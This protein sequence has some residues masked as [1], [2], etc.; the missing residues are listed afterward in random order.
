MFKAIGHHKAGGAEVLEALELP[1][2][3]LGER[4][5]W[6]EVRATSL[7]P[8]DPKIRQNF[9]PAE[10]GPRVLGY[11]AAG[12]VVRTGSG[13][14][15]FAPGD[16][17]FYA[18]SLVRQGSNASHQLVDERIVG[19][20]PKSASFV[21]AAALPLTCITAWELL[22]DRLRVTAD[23]PGTLL[24]LG[25]AGG[26]GSAMI[27][28]AKTKTK[29]RVIATASRAQSAQWVRS[30]GADEVVNH[31]E[32]WVAEAKSLGIDAVDHAVAL[33]ASEQHIDALEAIIKPQGQLGL[34]DDPTS[35]D[36]TK[37]KQKS[38]SL[39]WEFMFT[40]SM[41]QT[42]DM[43]AQHRLLNEISQMVD[44]KQIRTTLQENLGPLTVEKLRAAHERIMNG[45]SVGKLVF[46]AIA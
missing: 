28:I 39:H 31:R 2:P 1:E 35:F 8:A 19:K 37:F 10:G 44:A 29:Q 43:E 20:K 18:G 32:D 14:K 12:V 24:I 5:L 23:A 30:L 13:A 27:Q 21:E 38:I 3:E 33:N 46:E 15:H 11:D 42:E 25:A 41:F 7:N 26:V 9:P 16:E 22:F 4:D 34:I 6:V 40:R 45:R 17:V 36:L